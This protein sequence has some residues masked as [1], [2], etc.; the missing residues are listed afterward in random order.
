M[1][2][3][4]FKGRCEKKTLLK[5]EGV[6]RTYD[7]IQAAYADILS[8]DPDVKSFRCNVPLEGDCEAYMTD[9]VIE[10]MDGSIVVRECV[11]RHLIRKP[12]TIDMLCASQEYWWSHGI[13]DWKLIIDAKK[14]E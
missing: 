8:E 2:K 14:D 13:Y 1:R 4:K 3:K 9:F 6:C 5:C 12:K 7:A 10:M 11:F